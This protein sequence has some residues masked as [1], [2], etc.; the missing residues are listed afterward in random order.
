MSDI[1]N[2]NA[3]PVSKIGDIELGSLYGNVWVNCGVTANAGQSYNVS[4]LT[5]VGTGALG[6]SFTNPMID[7]DF[8][9]NAAVQIGANRNQSVYQQTT[10]LSASRCDFQYAG[11][12]AD[13]G[14]WSV[15][16][17]GAQI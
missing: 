3:S 6:V 17:I 4:S 10:N 5:D 2:T 12:A 8:S 16:I 14:R 1:F 15:V 13:P 11:A 7:S 9:A